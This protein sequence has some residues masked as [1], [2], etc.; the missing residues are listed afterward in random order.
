MLSNITREPKLNISNMNN[1]KIGKPR[2]PSY[3]SS[4]R[5]LSLDAERHLQFVKISDN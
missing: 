4:V 3:Q 2:R 5:K 1:K